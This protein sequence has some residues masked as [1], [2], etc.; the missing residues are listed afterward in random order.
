MKSRLKKLDVSLAALALIAIAVKGYLIGVSWPEAIAFP[1]LLVIHYGRAFLPRPIPE[2]TQE[3]ANKLIQD[4]ESLKT[5]ITKVKLR[6]GFTPNQQ[7]K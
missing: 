4:V 5:D 1:L 7:K 6:V 2:I 3:Q